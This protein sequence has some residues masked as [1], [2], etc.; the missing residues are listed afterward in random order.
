M[1]EEPIALSSA[2]F[3]VK[4]SILSSKQIGRLSAEAAEGAAAEDEAAG[5]W[6]AVLVPSPKGAAE[7]AVL[8]LGQDSDGR[9]RGAIG[10]WA[11]EH[12]PASTAPLRAAA[13]SKI[14]VLDDP[15]GQ[16]ECAKISHPTVVGVGENHRAPEPYS[17]GLSAPMPL[18]LAESAREYIVARSQARLAIALAGLAIGLALV[19][20]RTLMLTLALTLTLTPTPSQVNARLQRGGAGADEKAHVRSLLSEAFERLTLCASDDQL[21]EDDLMRCESAVQGLRKSYLIRDWEPR[22]AFCGVRHSAVEKGSCKYWQAFKATARDGCLP[23][24][25]PAEGR[26]LA[27]KLMAEASISEKSGCCEEEGCCE[28]ARPLCEP[29]ANGP[30]GVGEA[31]AGAP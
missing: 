6:W 3:D 21:P 16:Y 24:Q 9:L 26:A 28:K 31:E 12:G 13:A 14:A 25:P 10:W 1:E 2:P 19:P 23:S 5:D 20:T 8:C 17:S 11:A 7:E 22:C 27:E 30:A 15:L 18:Q 4:K 29:N